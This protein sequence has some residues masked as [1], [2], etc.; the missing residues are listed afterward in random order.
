[1]AD[2]HSAP[3][4]LPN[5]IAIDG[6]AASGKTSVGQALAARFGYR[7]LDTGMTYRA[8]TLVALRQHV[9]ASDAAS[10]AAVAESLDLHFAPDG[11]RVSLGE[12]DVTEII[13]GPDVE[14]NVSAYSAIPAVREIMVWL[15]RQFAEAGPAVLAGRDIGTVVLPAAPLKFYLLASEEARAKRRSLQAGTW[16]TNQQAEDARRDIAGR[17]LIDSSRATSPLSSASDAIVID[18]TELTLDELIAMVV[19][20]VECASN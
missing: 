8:L 2:S 12:E 4:A 15:Q 19:E 10:C 6:P 13:R 1:M 9:V 11:S 7:F 20:K 5:P 18:T 17:D 14:A 3:A 16:G